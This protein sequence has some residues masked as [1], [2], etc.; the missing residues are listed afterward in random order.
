[1]SNLPAVPIQ[2]GF[3]V[4]LVPAAQRKRVY[5]AYGLVGFLIGALTAGFAAVNQAMPP[6]W[7]VIALVVYTFSGPAF[8]ALAGANAVPTG[9]E[10]LDALA[11]DPNFNEGL[12]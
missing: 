7:L 12:S 11:A 3:L 2:Q 9:G 1:M 4:D 10:A 5:A 8:S 6:N